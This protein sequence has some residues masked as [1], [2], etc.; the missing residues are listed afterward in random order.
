MWNFI[1][2]ASFYILYPFLAF[3][4]GRQERARI[5]ICCADEVLLVRSWLGNSKWD[6]PGG[7][8][9]K[10]EDP[11]SGA[12]REIRE[13]LGIELNESSIQ[14]V[15]KEPFRSGLIR[16]TAHYFTVSL[17]AK[18]VQLRLQTS[19]IIEA[20]WF[21]RSTVNSLRLNQQHK[22]IIVSWYN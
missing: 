17:D 18:P 6:L 7:G 21:K 16:Y 4:L 3:Y 9:H 14:L 20:Q 13:E 22:R 19:E 11:L 12:A 8:L 2:R 1:G 15:A 5:V 10:H